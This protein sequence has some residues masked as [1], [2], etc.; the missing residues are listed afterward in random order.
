MEE[1]GDI[2]SVFKRFCTLS[3][4]IKASAEK[5][6]TKLMWNETL[7]WIGKCCLLSFVS[8]TFLALL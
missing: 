5:N 3:H 1:G 4:A 2:T 6:G 8:P 7:G